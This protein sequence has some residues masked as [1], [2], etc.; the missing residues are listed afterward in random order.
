M[1]LLDL[2]KSHHMRAVVFTILAVMLTGCSGTD[3][4]FEYIHLPGTEPSAGANMPF[5]SAIQVRSGNIV[6][7]SGTVGAPSPHS[8]PHI[9]SEFDHLD[10]SPEAQTIRVMESVKA[11]VE[12]AGGQLTDIVRVTRFVRNVGENQDAINRVMN[13]YWGPGHRPASTTVEIVRLATD[14]RFI[15]EVE[16]IAVLPN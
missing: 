13:R 1:Y 7:L 3:Q 2:Y 10:F 15:L 14:P 16:A 4:P 8:H 11:A 6:F 5:T 9:P 12:A